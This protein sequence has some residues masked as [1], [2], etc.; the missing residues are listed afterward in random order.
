MSISEHKSA[1]QKWFKDW[2]TEIHEYKYLILI[3]IVCLIISAI[4]TIFASTYVDRIPVVAV[5]DL[6]LDNIPA[7]N[8]NVIFSYSF[9]TL[10]V[11]LTVYTVFFR[12]KEFH[13]T[14]LLFSLL[15][16]TRSIFITLTHLGA[17]QGA[18][19]G[20]DAPGLYQLF[21]FRNDL[22]F[23]GHAAMP[24]MAFLIFRK[25][26]IGKLFLILTIILSATVLL[27]HIHYSIDVFSAFF[28]TYGVYKFG[29][30]L[31]DKKFW[32]KARVR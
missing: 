6:I 30:W 26:W 3:S 24:F 7:I 4:I 12:V 29:E 31:M 19:L 17:P 22:F 5:P 27:M 15:V 21:N 8:L 11:L 1:V 10:L 32:H 13:K 18:L 2:R 20:R 14:A 9:V 28:I 16:L 25:E 23:S